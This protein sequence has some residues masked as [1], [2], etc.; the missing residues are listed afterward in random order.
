VF[1]KYFTL[2][3]IFIKIKQTE[4]SKL[5]WLIETFGF[6]IRQL[7][8]MLGVSST[9][10]QFTLAGKRYSTLLGRETLEDSLFTPYLIEVDKKIFHGQI[11]IL[12]GG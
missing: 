11:R 1:I 9:F 7:A 2:P 8:E 6:S 4:I 5:H 12:N 3:L 10:V